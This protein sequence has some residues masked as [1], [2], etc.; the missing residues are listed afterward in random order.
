MKTSLRTWWLFAGIL[1]LGL[2]LRLSYIQAE[3][4]W[5]DEILSLDIYTSFASASEMV[6]YLREVEFHPPLYYLMM[7]PWSTWF[8]TSHFAIRFV[9][10][11]FGMGVIAGVFFWTRKLLQSDKTALIAAFLIAILPF[12]IE[13]SQEARPYIIFTF[14]GLIAAWSMWEYLRSE[15]QKY[16]VGYVLAALVGMY[17]HY[18]FVFLVFALGAWWLLDVLYKK[19]KQ[20]MRAFLRLFI[21]HALVFIGFWWWLDA[22]LYKVVLANF[23][24]LS[25]VRQVFTI[26]PFAFVPRIFDGLLWM[27]TTGFVSISEILTKFVTVLAV[28]VAVFSLEK[29][30]FLKVGRKVT[31]W[32]KSPIYYLAWILLF[33]IGLFVASPQS[34]PYTDIFQ[35]HVIFATVPIAM[36]VAHLLV[37]LGRKKGGIMLLLIFTSFIPSMARVL[38]NDVKSNVY[39][40]HE[41]EGEFLA[42]HWQEGDIVIIWTTNARTHLARF[43]PEGAI[44]E[45][46][47]P[48]EYF[49]EGID[50]W[51]TNKTLG[52]LENEMQVRSITILSGNENA[53][54]AFK[55]MDQILERHKPK[56]VWI[57]ASSV[58]LADE[59]RE[60]D[61]R[62]VYRS[63]YPLFRLDLFERPEEIVVE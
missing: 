60:N 14:F 36:L 29:E 30:H 10:L 5:S 56:R 28:G 53:Q 9:S 27:Q 43:L 26:R 49:D 15:K 55:K 24:L 37:S 16:A 59:Y 41:I 50:P 8:G 32:H 54:S 42:T 52:L 3:P 13:F 45:A 11:V 40:Q 58:T 48:I 2:L 33:P 1:F 39:F 34:I 35:R 21:A 22:I 62:W 51:R 25:E 7:R 23:E 12:Q 17:L 20:R 61:W 38:D 47:Y 19:P 44:V 63:I 57:Y 6:R 46:I 4:F 18:S 31:K